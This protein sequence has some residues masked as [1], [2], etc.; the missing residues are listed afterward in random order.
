MHGLHPRSETQVEKV[1]EGC[2]ALSTPRPG[3]QCKELTDYICRQ[4]KQLRCKARGGTCLLEAAKMVS[5]MLTLLMTIKR[6]PARV[7]A[8]SGWE[9]SAKPS[10]RLHK[11]NMHVWCIRLNCRMRMKG[12]AIVGSSSANAQT[13]AASGVADIFCKLQPAM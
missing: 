9:S 13:A 3:A 10:Q 2:E 7:C 4:K 1:L 11:S 6:H 8:H 5:A 12:D